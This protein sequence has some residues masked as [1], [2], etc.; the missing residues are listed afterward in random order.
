MILV[1]VSSSV[2]IFFLALVVMGNVRADSGS[3]R[4]ED[5]AVE[6]LYSGKN[7][8]LDE[9]ARTEGK[10]MLYRSAAV[11]GSVNFA[12]HYIVF[13]GDC[14]AGAVC[15][16][17]IDAKTGK[18]AASFP[19]AYLLEGDGGYFDVVFRPRSR[20]LVISGVAADPE[21]GKNGRL[22]QPKNRIRYFEM[23]S[24]KLVVVKIGRD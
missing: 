13:T 6:S 5:Y 7:H 14:G 22:L 12:G 18:I 11:K 19:N 16:E 20:L 23:K 15:G 3:P 1:E 10:W 2:L 21:K 17:I 8:A 24:G 9:S 4:F